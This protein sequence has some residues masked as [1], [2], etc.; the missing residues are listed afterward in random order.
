MKKSSQNAK[1][2][3]KRR[4]FPFGAETN[5]VLRIAEV[6]A[7][8]D[9]C[10]HEGNTGT[11]AAMRRLARTLWGSIDFAPAAGARKARRSAAG[12]AGQMA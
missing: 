9:Q 6:A 10:D 7:L 3:S 2:A 1:K 4:P 8:A 11:A 5:V 12:V